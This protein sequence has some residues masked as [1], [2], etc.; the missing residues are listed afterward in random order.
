MNEIELKN[1]LKNLNSDMEYRYMINSLDS[2]EFS[3][4]GILLLENGDEG[5]VACILAGLNNEA[6]EEIIN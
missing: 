4:V 3:E 6:T 2:H 1:Q 5:E